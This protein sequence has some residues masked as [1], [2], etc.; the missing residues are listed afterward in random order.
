MPKIGKLAKRVTNSAKRV[1]NSAKSAVGLGGYSTAWVLVGVLIIAVI[2]LCVFLPR[3]NQKVKS[4]VGFRENFLANAAETKTV[5]TINSNIRNL[6]N[7]VK[8]NSQGYVANVQGAATTPGTKAYTMQMINNEFQKYPGWT[9]T[10]WGNNAEN[11]MKA[12]SFSELDKMNAQLVNTL[13]ADQA[14]MRDYGQMSANPAYQFFSLPSNDNNNAKVRQRAMWIRIADALAS[15]KD[16]A[17]APA[18]VPAPMPMPI[19]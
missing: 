10:S 1:T 11:I 19:S 16:Q 5:E 4:M 6:V 9:S 13:K 14:F 3:C 12:A 15:L 8:P 7:N 18:P 17:Q 2:L